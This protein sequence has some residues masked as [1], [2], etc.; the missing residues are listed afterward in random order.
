VKDD[1]G[2]NRNTFSAVECIYFS[3][4]PQTPDA[5]A[6]RILVNSRDIFFRFDRDERRRTKSECTHFGRVLLAQAF[7]S[8]A[9]FIHSQ[10]LG[11]RLWH[12]DDHF[13][14]HLAICLALW[15]DTA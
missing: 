5:P 4:A 3:L 6:G 9:G 11:P 15:I 2:Q 12:I 14:R 1:L 8:L 10:L 13:E 7:R